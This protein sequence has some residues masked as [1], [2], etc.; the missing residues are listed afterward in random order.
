MHPGS[1][2][3][4]S[5]AK[6]LTRILRVFTFTVEMSKQI[7]LLTSGKRTAERCFDS[8]QNREPVPSLKF[9]TRNFKAREILP[10]SPLD[11]TT[12]TP[13]IK[14]CFCLILDENKYVC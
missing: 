9:L 4:I 14:R 12:K 11:Y 13:F 6:S 3:G 1:I 7:I 8:N 5:T 2:P 10:A